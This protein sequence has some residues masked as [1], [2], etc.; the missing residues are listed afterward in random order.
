MFWIDSGRHVRKLRLQP[1]EVSITFKEMY[2]SP[3]QAQI[4]LLSSIY[5]AGVSKTIIFW[6]K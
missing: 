5:K 1:L 4:H 6:K 3:G 2:G